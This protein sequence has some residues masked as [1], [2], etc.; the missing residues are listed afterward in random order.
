[1]SQHD[2]V[3]LDRGILHSSNAHH[4]SA[5]GGADLDR[6]SRGVPTTLRIDGQKSPC[7]IQ[8]PKLLASTF[9]LI[10]WT[11][12]GAVQAQEKAP[13]TIPS[14][15]IPVPTS[16]SPKLQELLSYRGDVELSFPKSPEDWESL[17]HN[18]IQPTVQQ[19]DALRHKFDV[20]VEPDIME[21][22][23]CY[24]VAPRNI[25]ARN[26]NRLILYLHP[27]GFIWG[28]GEAGTRWAIEIAGLTGYK[29]VVVDYRL[30][31]DH[32]FP[33]AIDD[34]IA[35]W[36]G[37]TKLE[38][39]SNIAIVGGSV[40]GGLALS[41][42]QRARLKGLPMPGAVV[43]VSPSAADLSKASDSF[44]TNAGVD[45]AYDGFW[46]AVFR[47]YAN[48]RDLADPAVSPVYADF[49][50]FPPTFLVSGTR[51]LYLSNTVRVQRKLLQ[52]NVPTHLIVGEGMFHG[53]FFNAEIPELR[54]IYA[55]ISRFLDANLGH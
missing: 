44:Y 16:V 40:G 5:F 17:K 10:A 15:L 4:A 54:E 42:V 25:K 31:P 38:N 53:A 45:G 47:L 13:R 21:G 28:G 22:V 36:E 35:V 37:V 46:E 12:G 9:V 30:L 14:R 2:Y 7:V 49:N 39:P 50:G 41:I 51:D 52:A 24:V 8:L 43:S 48:R 3:V 6:N 29:I 27:G 18:A 32:P 11:C 34:A 55:E 19:L 26:R 23:R 20:T 1:M 33:A